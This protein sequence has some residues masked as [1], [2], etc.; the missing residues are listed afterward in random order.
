LPNRT[1]CLTKTGASVT[2]MMESAIRSSASGLLRY[3]DAVSTVGNNIANSNTTAYKEQRT[4][5]AAQLSEIAN[6]RGA[7]VDGNAGDGVTISRLRAN[8]STGSTSPTGRELDVALTG[9]GFFLAGD[10]NAPSLTRVGI[11]QVNQDGLLTTTEGLPVLG[12]SG[13]D[14]Q[15][16]GKINMTDLNQ[17]PLA[18]TQISVFGNVNGS[19][20]QTKVPANPITFKEL[21]DAASFVSTQSAY[22]GT[23]VRHD[24]QLFYFKTS[25]NQW[26]VQAYVNGNDVGQAAD[27]PVRLGQVDLNFNTIG[28]IPLEQQ[29]QAAININPAWGGNAGQ[30]GLTISLANITQF[31]GG[32]RIVNVQ[33]DGRGNGDVIGFEIAKDGKVFGLT[34]SG[35]RVQAGT[36]ALGMV[37]NKDGLLQTSGSLYSVTPESGAL[38]I[39]TAGMGGRGAMQGQALELSNVDL[40]KQFVDM[41]VLQRGYQANSQAM[42]AASDLLKNTIAMIR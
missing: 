8:F 22:D 19:G 20:L 37:N 14:N 25:T 7:S 23:G 4:E 21:N 12:Y 38:R 17:Q 33:Q 42:S 16:L 1:I 9:S 29:A 15:V 13:T 34:A 5:F 27:Q 3:G 26:T 18:T 36:L 35:E 39:G 11:F 41:I 32:S 2:A 6:D 28:Q 31:A 40:P 24:V 10:P 30:A